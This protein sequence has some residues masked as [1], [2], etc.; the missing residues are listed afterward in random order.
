MEV[1]KNVELDGYKF[2]IIFNAKKYNLGWLTT[3]CVV[4][5][6]E[7]NEV[8]YRRTKL[9]EYTEMTL[10]EVIIDIAKNTVRHLP[11]ILERDEIEELKNW[12]GIITIS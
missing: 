5:D 4:K 7:K 3:N 12:D 9:I 11:K 10:K 2:L 8:V 1:I 6:A